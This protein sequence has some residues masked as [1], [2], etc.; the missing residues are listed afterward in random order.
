MHSK[1]VPEVAKTR[2][3]NDATELS[4]SIGTCNGGQTHIRPVLLSIGVNCTE[5][6]KR[7]KET[8]DR[9]LRI[10]SVGVPGVGQNE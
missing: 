2:K 6:V 7:R 4:T 1:G 5:F 3:A 8:S 10:H 9:T